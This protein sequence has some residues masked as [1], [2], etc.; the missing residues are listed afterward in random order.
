MH[1]G[2]LAT[3]GIIPVAK[4]YSTCHIQIRLKVRLN[5]IDPRLGNHTITLSITLYQTKN[6][7]KFGFKNGFMNQIS[8]RINLFFLLS[9]LHIN[10]IHILWMDGWMDECGLSPCQRP[11]YCGN[12][13]HQRN[14]FIVAGRMYLCFMT[15]LCLKSQ[16]T[17]TVE[18][19][20]IYLNLPPGVSSMWMGCQRSCLSTL[21]N[22]IW[23]VTLPPTDKKKGE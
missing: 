14:Y 20:A 3:R 8:G 17:F 10:D 11:F 19:S 18:Y 12:C 21:Q 23:W 5:F 1:L 7:L 15:E 4:C 6:N 22:I 2:H 16:G 13:H 9:R